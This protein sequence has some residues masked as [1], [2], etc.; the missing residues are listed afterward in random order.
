MGARQPLAA[1]RA[2]IARCKC[3]MPRMPNGSCGVPGCSAAGHSA[4]PGYFR[5]ET[6]PQP[7]THPGLRALRRRHP[8]TGRI[9]PAGLQSG[10]DAQAQDEARRSHQSGRRTKP[11]CL[12]YVPR[13]QRR[14]GHGPR[15]RVLSKTTRRA[16]RI[17]FCLHTLCSIHRTFD[18]GE[19]ARYTS[20]IVGG[21][22]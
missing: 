22:R 15:S 6:G 13:L 3:D 11:S 8:A 7:G 18:D 2:P 16:C 14:S 1:R 19:C 9:P 12:E 10:K 21:N 4:Y 17:A 5:E 20:Y